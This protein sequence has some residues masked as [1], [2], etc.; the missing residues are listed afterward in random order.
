MADKEKEY[1]PYADENDDWETIA[2][3]ND[4]TGLVPTPPMT[5]G[6]AESYSDLMN[7]PQPKGKVDNGMQRIHPE[8]EKKR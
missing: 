7:I 1:P 4:C 3:S 2:S 8:K 5:E 6:E